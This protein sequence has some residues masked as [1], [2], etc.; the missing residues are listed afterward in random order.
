[1][2][3][4]RL[5]IALWFILL[6]FILILVLVPQENIYGANGIAKWVASNG[7][8][9]AWVD[10]LGLTH[11]AATWP[12]KLGVGVFALVAL[13]SLLQQFA[14]AYQQWCRGGI[15][16]RWQPVKLKQKPADNWWQKAGLKQVNQ[17]WLRHPV[18][19]FAIP[20]FHLA[21][22]LIIIGGAVT[23]LLRVQATVSLTEG[24]AFTGQQQLEEIKKGPWADIKFPAEYLGLDKFDAN[25]TE[26]AAYVVRLTSKGEVL[27]REKIAVNEN[28]Q[29]HGYTLYLVRSGYAPGLEVKEGSR[30]LLAGYVAIKEESGQGEI[31]LPGEQA[32]SLAYDQKN[33]QLLVNGLPLNQGETRTLPQGLTVAFIDLRYWASFLLVKDPGL[34]WIVAGSSAGIIAL[35]F[36]LF[37]PPLE[38]VLNEEKG[39]W[40]LK[41]R[42]KQWQSGIVAELRQVMQKGEVLGE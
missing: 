11:F 23:Y 19:L 13:Y 35:F 17:G 8:W 24:Q 1:M 27:A 14:L 26:P 4:R 29:W 12:F 33:Q 25:A 41:A 18:S 15:G 32:L 36:W 10:R 5:T 7:S 28:L 22:I 39:N 34:Y 2:N 37:R 40:I 30:V 38:I 3:I 9:A 20:L 21:L 42:R 31:K 6:V 16:G